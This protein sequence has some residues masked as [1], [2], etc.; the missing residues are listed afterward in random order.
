MLIAMLEAPARK[1]EAAVLP[2]FLRRWQRRLLVQTVRVERLAELRHA[3]RGAQPDVLHICG[4][5]TPSGRMI[6]KD[7]GGWMQSWC[8]KEKLLQAV[9]QTRRSH[10][11]RLVYLNAPIASR[12]FAAGNGQIQVLAGMQEAPDEAVSRKFTK[13]FYGA[14]LQGEALLAAF[15]AG[16]AVLPPEKR[17]NTVQ[18]RIAPEVNPVSWRLVEQHPAKGKKEGKFVVLRKESF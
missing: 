8:T 14:L 7:D 6:F 1:T 12:D 11:F 3:V 10:E 13:G 17:K 4:S 5:C 15:R 18:L 2:I 16:K 9:T